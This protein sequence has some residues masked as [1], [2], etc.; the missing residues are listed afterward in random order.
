[1]KEGATAV[2][3]GITATSVILTGLR[4]GTTYYFVVKAVNSHG[5]STA[6]NEAS[7]E[8]VAPPAAPGSLT[9]TAGAGQVGLHWTPSAGATG[10]AVYL[11]TRAGG[12]SASADVTV[13][14][15]ASG[16]TVSGL[17][18]GTKYYFIVKATNKIGASTA[19]NE[20]SATPN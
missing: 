2:R 19:S 11:G 5:S 12:E 6:S 10:Y 17:S 1:G 9:A 8:P 3:S 15:N 18:K 7:A 14:G 13:L 16:V 4:N 20:A